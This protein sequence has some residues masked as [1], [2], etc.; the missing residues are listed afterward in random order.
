LT[1]CSI[2]PESIVNEIVYEVFKDSDW[3]LWGSLDYLLPL[4]AEAS[5]EQF[6]RAVEN[7]M[8]Q[9]PCPFDELFKQESGGVIGGNHL[10]GLLW[11]LETLAW[12]EKYLV[13]VTVALG[14]LASRDPGGFWA[15]RP[16]NSL[17][18]IY[19]PWLP[20]TC[21][22]I[23]KRKIA[24]R[25]LLTEVP[26]VGWKLLI[27]LIPNQFQTSTGS[28]KPKWR[29]IILDEESNRVSDK[30]YWQQV[31]NYCE[32][33]VEVAEHN[34]DNLIELVGYIDHLPI[35]AVES[36][37]RIISSKEITGKPE[38]ERID[39]WTALVKISSKHKHFADA[40][41]ALNSEIITKIEN[42]A[43]AI[44]P[45]NPINL[46]QILFNNLDTEFYEEPENWKEQSEKFEQ[47]RQNSLKEIYEHGGA[48]AIINFSKLVNHPT[49]VGF[50]LGNITEL[51]MDDRILP[52]LLCQEGTK[53]HQFTRAFIKARIQ[54]VG[55]TWVD[56]LELEKWSEKQIIQFFAWLPFYKESW[57]RAIRLLG[58]NEKEYW[59]KVEA[60]PS[61][62]DSDLETA[63]NK[64]LHFDRPK[65]AVDCLFALYYHKKPLNKN[66]VVQALLQ[67]V[68]SNETTNSMD[69]YHYVQLIKKLQDDSDSNP[70][71]LFKVEWAYLP[72][73]K[74]FDGITPKFLENRLATDPGFFNEMIAIAYRSRKETELEEQPIEEQPTEEQQAVARNAYKLLSEW[75]TPPGIRSDG[76]FS[77]ED[78]NNWLKLSKEKCEET[79]HLDVALSHIGRVLFYVPADSTGLWIH[80]GVA[81]ALNA[82]D[83]EKMRSGFRIEVFNSRGPHW[84]DPSGKPEKELAEEYKGWAEEIENAGYHRF[85]TTLRG[86]SD[87]YYDDAERIIKESQEEKN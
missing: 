64:L 35:N 22:P 27:N 75:K 26:S 5:P 86:I 73:L 63:I 14:D 10:S 33:A 87:S 39:L 29:K 24:V 77:E 44:A 23:E 48:E 32:L 47:R 25:T 19:L 51:Q 15:N 67:V 62:I 72:L 55:W 40:D 1:N 78:F 16:A 45:K 50:S 30:D 38:K 61:S 70:D 37:L 69:N 57:E 60:N 81:N 82:R 31:S 49:S 84:V 42:V 8:Q 58:D 2:K 74:N 9:T 53:L 43:N 17:K 6:L 59:E 52:D 83:G 79:G 68:D 66:I 18:T 46:H 80:R 85:A 4:I 3:E 41:W 28:Y 11:A 71:D 13:R 36:I 21:A 7:V 65:A 12:D 20:Q 56:S 54:K 76:N 34:I